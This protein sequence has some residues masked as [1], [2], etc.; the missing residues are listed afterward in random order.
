MKQT[1]YICDRCG[2]VE[3]SA[4]QLVIQFGAGFVDPDMTGLPDLC[5]GD[6]CRQCQ[7]EF[8]ERFFN[9]ISRFIR[10]H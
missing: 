4:K 9:S 3:D 5:T 7:R 2:K 8:G 1:M 10:G 6:L